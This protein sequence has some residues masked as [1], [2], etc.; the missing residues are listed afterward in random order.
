MPRDAAMNWGVGE[1]LLTV[2][3]IGSLWTIGYLVAPTLFAVLEDRAL[4][5]LLAGRLFTIGNYLGLICGS[6]LLL[7][8]WLNPPEDGRRGWRAGLLAVML[9]IILVSQFVLQP[10]LADLKAQGGGA[11]F[12]RLHGV[13]A[14]LYLVNS[15][16]GLAWVAFARR[17]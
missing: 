16:L 15:L 2:L 3:W 5:G 1:R 7:G 8:V 17:C 10:V 4:A 9:G 6:L 12:V 13:S 11:A 14:S